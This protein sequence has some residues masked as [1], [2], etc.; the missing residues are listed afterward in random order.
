M[1]IQTSELRRTSGAA[2]GGDGAMSPRVA[3][4]QAGPM[5]RKIKIKPAS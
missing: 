5:G 1:A 4:L 3:L 2:G